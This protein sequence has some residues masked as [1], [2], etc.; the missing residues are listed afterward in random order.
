MV[1]STEP[2]VLSMEMLN[3]NS[4]SHQQ[5]SEGHFVLMSFFFFGD[6]GSAV[7]RVNT[8]FERFELQFEMGYFGLVTVEDEEPV[9]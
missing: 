3:T 8:E 4:H 1:T 5:C 2:S 7:W 6:F 9:E